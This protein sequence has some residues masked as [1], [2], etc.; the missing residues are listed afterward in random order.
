MAI[1]FVALAGYFCGA[2]TTEVLRFDT[3]QACHS[4]K[5]EFEKLTDSL[6]KPG[7]AKYF[8]VDGVALRNIERRLGPVDR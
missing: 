7:G 8:C 6:G 2:N 5:G 3:I 4:A 1:L